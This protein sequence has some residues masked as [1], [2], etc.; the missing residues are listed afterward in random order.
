MDIWIQCFKVLLKT[1][2][3]TIYLL[4]KYVDDVLLICNNLKLGT[5]LEEGKLVQTEESIT[6]DKESG[7]TREE[8][9]LETARQADE[10]ILPFLKFTG[11]VSQGPS[12]SIT[13]LDAKLWYGEAEE[14]QPWYQGQ[15]PGGKEVPGQQWGS[16]NCKISCNNSMVN[17][18]QTNQTD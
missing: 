2:G 14:Q 10:T 3:F 13:C 6:E 12:K 5:R 1:L 7:I 17:Q 4:K 18:W 11:E 16:G 8:L 9:T 15:A